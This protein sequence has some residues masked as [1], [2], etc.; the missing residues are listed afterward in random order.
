[1]ITLWGSYY[2]YYY[3]TDGETEAWSRKL[4]C[5][6]SHRDWVR[7]RVC[8]Q[9]DSRVHALNHCAAIKEKGKANKI[10]QS[11]CS[12][13]QVADY[14]AYLLGHDRQMSVCITRLGVFCK[15][16]SMWEQHGVYL[17]QHLDMLSFVVINLLQSMHH[18]AF[19]HAICMCQSYRWL[20]GCSSHLCVAGYTVKMIY[21]EKK[22]ICPMRQLVFKLDRV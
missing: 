21:V 16:M 15:C 1:M 5:T 18:S 8:I 11:T 6:K 4:I 22:N 13:F 12:A 9:L 10:H 19:A 14:W 3:F 7:V 20:P 2:Y 17:E